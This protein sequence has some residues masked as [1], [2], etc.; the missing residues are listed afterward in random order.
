MLKTNVVRLLTTFLLL[1]LGLAGGCATGPA[2]D[3]SKVAVSRLSEM[4]MRR[5]EP[6][7]ALSLFPADQAGMTDAA[8]TE[9]LNGELQLPD[10][11][12]MAVVPVGETPSFT[13]YAP[14]FAEQSRQ[15]EGAFFN[16]L[17]DS[18]R[19]DYVQKLPQ[20]LRPTRMTVPDLRVAA[21]RYRADLV[22]IIHTRTR[23]YENDRLLGRDRVRA[24]SSVEAVLVDVRSGTIPFSTDTVEDFL[25][26][27]EKGDLRFRDTIAR[28]NQE[29]VGKAWLR[30]AGETA[31]FLD[32]QPAAATAEAK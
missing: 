29:A 25:A 31:A 15:L 9:V 11:V 12:R 8:L 23:T 21:A 2:I 28:A 20:M 16:T 19:I 4:E 26:V 3:P 22:L 1:A 18:E 10:R 7:E 32:E 24:F 17:S 14:E 30:V 27:K 6:L 13:G 5:A